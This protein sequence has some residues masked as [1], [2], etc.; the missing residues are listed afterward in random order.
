MQFISSK[1]TNYDLI[2]YL[3]SE[4]PK[5]D[6]FLV[7]EEVAVELFDGR[8]V[9]IPFG[10]MTDAHSTPVWLHSLLPHFDS[11]TNLAAIVHDYLY[12]HFEVFTRERR[13]TDWMEDQI[14]G[15]DRKFADD[16][17]LALMEQMAPGH[18]RNKVYY[19]AVRMFGWVNWNRF[20]DEAIK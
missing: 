10:F 8:V 3:S 11:R 9:V 17:Y 12:I 16:A 7:G 15:G 18:W 13:L 2:V 20:R 6:Q 19:R 4:T 14:D 5:R 1:Q